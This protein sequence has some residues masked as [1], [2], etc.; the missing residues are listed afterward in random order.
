MATQ[1]LEERVVIRAPAGTTLAI[2]QAAISARIR[3]SDFVRE[4]L[5]QALAAHGLVQ[6]DSSL[7]S[8]AARP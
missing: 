2:E 7:V 1:E 6:L 5:L 8:R 3:P 4:V